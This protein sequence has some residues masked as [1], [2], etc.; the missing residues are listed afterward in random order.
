M[1]SDQPDAQWHHWGYLLFM[2]VP[3]TWI[4]QSLEN[5][6]YI[7]SVPHL[8]PSELLDLHH[9]HQQVNKMQ[10]CTQN[11]HTEA[12]HTI[13]PHPLHPVSASAAPTIDLSS[14]WALT[15]RRS[16]G[17]NIKRE[18]HLHWGQIPALDRERRKVS[19]LRLHPAAA[20]QVISAHMSNMECAACLSASGVFV[21]TSGIK[22]HL[23]G[24]NLGPVF[25]DCVI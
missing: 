15:A 25:P 24:V 4:S 13:T 8:L 18:S 5:I 14:R 11:K 23:G 10:Q 16:G 6:S 2:F 21:S 9:R 17:Q 12:R 20:S 19:K 1:W 3:K 7:T 22:G